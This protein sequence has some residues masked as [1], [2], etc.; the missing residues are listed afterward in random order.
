MNRAFIVVVDVEQELEDAEDVAGEL[1][2]VLGAHFGD[3]L[4][5]VNVWDSPNQ[6]ETTN[7][8]TE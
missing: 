1:E 3:D 5:S 8:N 4:V 7:N 2:Q 6:R